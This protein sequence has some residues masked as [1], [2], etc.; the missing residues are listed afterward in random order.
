MER[1]RFVEHRGHRIVLVDFRGLTVP[2]L[3]LPELEKVR[4]FFAALPADGSHLTLTDV[5]DTRYNGE[6]VQAFKELTTHNRPY[7]KA[8]A[9]VTNTLFHQVA[10]STVALFSK[11]ILQRFD[12]VEPAMDWLVAQVDG[13]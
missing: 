13:G 12:E 9:V 4:R 6:I 7:V 1:T 2:T 11:R 5:R 8:A 10:I 3:A